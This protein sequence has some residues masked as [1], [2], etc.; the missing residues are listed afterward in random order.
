[1]Y[2]STLVLETTFYIFA[3]KNNSLNRLAAV[4]KKGPKTDP[5]QVPKFLDKLLDCRVKYRAR[6]FL[7]RQFSS[8]IKIKTFLH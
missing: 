4:C 1:M 5:L 2:Y 6:I 7:N 8:I 3:S